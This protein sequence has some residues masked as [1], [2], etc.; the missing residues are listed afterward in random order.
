[1][2]FVAGDTYEIP[3]GHDVRAV[4]IEIRAG[5]HTGDVEIVQG[6]VYG[7]V[8]HAAARQVVSYD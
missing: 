2:D 1:M 8:V 7:V 6:D 3:P 5:C 4:G